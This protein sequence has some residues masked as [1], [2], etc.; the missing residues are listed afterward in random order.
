MNKPE[1]LPCPFCG[2][3]HIGGPYHDERDGMYSFSCISRP[4]TSCA[5]MCGLTVD[6]ARER[7]NTRTP[8]KAVS[9][10]DGLVERLREVG[11]SQQHIDT[12]FARSTNATGTI[13]EAADTIERLQSVLSDPAGVHL[14]TL[15][16]G[17]AKMTPAQIGHLYRGEEGTQVI[18]EIRR[19]S[20]AGELLEGVDDVVDTLRAAAV[21]DWGLCLSP[22]VLKGLAE[23]IERLMKERDEAQRL[24]YVPGLRR[25]AKCSLN[26]ISST[27]SASDGGI[28]A[29][30]SPQDCLNGCGPMWP[31]T[32]RQAGNDLS[33]RL[34]ETRF[35]AALALGA[36]EQARTN[37]TAWHGAVEVASVI[38]GFPVGLTPS[39]FGEACQQ[40][41]AR[42]VNGPTV[43][44]RV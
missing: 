20:A 29:D 38:L 5:S 33:D 6:S 18:A 31:V 11:V 41:A 36:L 19:Q 10:G 22:D 26:L 1:L 35:F 13:R 21:G 12:D 39:E 15:R 7:W 25:C 14:N 32:E 16:G 43:Q 34:D 24:A 30:N 2:G 44:E 4:G 40:A 42:V 23:A 8:A 28:T 17:I 27:F 9:E 37:A 3:K